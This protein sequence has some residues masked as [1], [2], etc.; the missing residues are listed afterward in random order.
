[1]QTI[2]IQ[3]EKSAHHNKIT[4]EF[5]YE[6]YWNYPRPR[7]IYSI[8]FFLK[9][10]ITAFSAIVFSPVFFVSVMSNSI[11]PQCP[12]NVGKQIIRRYLIFP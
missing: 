4:E 1:M 9:Y 8:I 2:A 11:Q 5:I 3:A 12:L 10:I 6:S 7:V